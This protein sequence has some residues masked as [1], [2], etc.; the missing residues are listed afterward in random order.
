[1][2]FDCIRREEFAQCLPPSLVLHRLMAEQVEWFSNTAR[3]IIGTVAGQV[4]HGWNYAVLMADKRG[5]L[6]VSKLGGDTYNLDAARSRFLLEMEVAEKA[7]TEIARQEK[8]DAATSRP[9]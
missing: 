6:R 9:L 4:E 1:M 2:S 8:M 3:N 7:A 5:H